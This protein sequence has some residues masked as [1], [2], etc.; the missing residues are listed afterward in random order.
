MPHVQRRCNGCRRSVPQG[1]RAC[2][3]CGSRG[4]SWIARYRDPSRRE[5]SRS[6]LRRVDA[7]RYL[8]T[9]E[10]AK[11]RNEWVDPA[12]GRVALS[13]FADEWWAGTTSLAAHTR[14][15]YRSLID[16]H[17]VPF[18]GS[19]PLGSIQIRD[20][21]AFTAAL[22]AKG[23]APK[24]IRHAYTL[25]MEVLRDGVTN[26][27]RPTREQRRRMLP[28]PTPKKKR[29]LTA[30]DIDVLARTEPLAPRYSSLVL[31]G[32]F[33]ALRWGEL[34]GLRIHSLRLFERK[35]E[36]VE[37]DQGT[38]PKWGSAGTITIPTSI[39]GELARHIDTFG[40]DA[41]GHV[42]TSPEGRPLSYANF[43][44]RVW[45]P[46]VRAAGLE[47]FTPHGLR[48]T[49]V[50]LAIEA[51]AHPK[52]IQELCRHRSITTTLNE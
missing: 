31:L 6:F 10:T 46:A 29:Y 8:A 42:F 45:I 14:R 39:S 33:G 40:V 34:A 22:A 5:R 24:T 38:E 4:V 50:A 27:P 20:V 35:V 36:V 16:V 13:N 21:S 43:Y 9:V 17:I 41:E 51:G 2:P 48:H 18:F 52:Q 47:P 23:L 49:A 15:R 30:H 28:R 3:A 44:R 11:L 1:V 12:A 19:R 37:T 32:A 25:L 26:P 7:E